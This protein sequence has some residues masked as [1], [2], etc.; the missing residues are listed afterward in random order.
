MAISRCDHTF[1]I[2]KKIKPPKNKQTTV[3]IQLKAAMLASVSKTIKPR[4][5]RLLR[6]GE[7]SVS[8]ALAPSCVRYVQCKQRRGQKMADCML[9]SCTSHFL[10]STSAM[11]H[12][13][14]KR[15]K[16]LQ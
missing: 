10:N 9:Y 5:E 13:T 4:L 1:L 12:G 7:A 8:G 14:R 16:H 3:Q 15:M 2:I 11:S 6:H